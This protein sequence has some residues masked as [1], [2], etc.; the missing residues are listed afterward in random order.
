VEVRIIATTNRD[1]AKEVKEK[2]FRGDL[3]Y[4]LNVLQ[5][6]VSPLRERGND[7]YML[8]RYFVLRANPKGQRR[9]LF[10]KEVMGL[11]S[12]YPW[13]GNIRELKNLV[14]R[15]ANLTDHFN[16]NLTETTKWIREELKKP[17]EV[18][19]TSF[20]LKE[21]ELNLRE[22]EQAWIRKICQSAPLKKT[23]LAKRLGISRTTLWKKTKKP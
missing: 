15:L 7:A 3:F 19:E 5:L 17:D 2:R 9:F 1:L 21:R 10:N 4:R 6:N 14:E 8:F 20:D 13:P 16:R 11:L 18:E 12:N 22:L 23:E